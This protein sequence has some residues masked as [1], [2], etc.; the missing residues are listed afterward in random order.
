[1]ASVEEQIQT[2]LRNIESKTGKSQAELFALVRAC[3]L[4]KHGELVAHL[5]S[6]LGLGHGDA[7]TLA[8]KA[9]ASDGASVA[10]EKTA[11]GTDP[12]DDWYAG[13]KVALR[14]IHDAVLGAVSAFGGDI[15]HSPK[16][17][18]VSLR[19]KKQF[20]TVGPA[21]QTQVEVGL[22]LKGE[23]RRRPRDRAAGGRHVYPPRPVGRGLGSGRRPRRVAAAGLRPV[24][25]R[26]ALR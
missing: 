15:E 18:Y 14:P 26:P 23:P 12:A 17:G 4:S 8:H 2:Q 22:N 25:L 13:P 5:K 21:T 7:N 11:L 24:G 19:R 6:T 10:A 9:R 1:M 16:K 20:A 3:G